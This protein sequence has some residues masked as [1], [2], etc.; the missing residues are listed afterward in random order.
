MATA[1]PV[2]WVP[3]ANTSYATN[4]GIMGGQGKNEV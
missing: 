2:R 1:A 4:D 3:M